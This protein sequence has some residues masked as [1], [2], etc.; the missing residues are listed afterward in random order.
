MWGFLV[1][2]FSAAQFDVTLFSCKERNRKGG[3]YQSFKGTLR[4]ITG[5]RPKPLKLMIMW[6][7]VAESRCFVASGPCVHHYLSVNSCSH[8]ITEAPSWEIISTAK[9]GTLV[10]IT[11]PHT[12]YDLLKFIGF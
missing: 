2:V 7:S 1:V 11:V 4:K 12:Q 10:C 6:F 5:E 3:I 8:P 9:T